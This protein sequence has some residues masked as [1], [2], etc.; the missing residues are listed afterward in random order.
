MGLALVVAAILAYPWVSLVIVV[1]PAVLGIGMLQAVGGRRRVGVALIALAVVTTGVL[2][3]GLER[4]RVPSEAMEPTLAVG[5]HLVV[6]RT[7]L[8][9]PG[10]GDVVVFHPPAGAPTNRCDAPVDATRQLCPRSTPQELLG[11]DYVKRIVAGPGDTVALANGRVIRNGVAQRE[12]F[13]RACEPG[14]ACTFSQPIRVPAGE[15]FVLGDNRGASDD[16]RFWGPVPRSWVV[17][18]VLLHV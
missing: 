16:S 10:V 2:V 12:G 11:V 9:S 18:V 4:F 6:D 5:T 13:I 15:I 17:G 14:E 1:G 3:E 8:L 7:G